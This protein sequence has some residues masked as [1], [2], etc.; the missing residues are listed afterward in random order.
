MLNV[1]CIPFRSDF[2]LTLCNISSSSWW[3]FYFCSNIYGQ[4][5][6]KVWTTFE[7]MSMRFCV[8]VCVC[9][10]INSYILQVDPSFKMKLHLYIL[11]FFLAGYKKKIL[12]AFCSMDYCPGFFEMLLFFYIFYYPHWCINYWLNVDMVC[13]YY[14]NIALRSIMSYLFLHQIHSFFLIVCQL[15]LALTLGTFHLFLWSNLISTVCQMQSF[16]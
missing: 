11:A 15:E 7:L 5:K 3:I 9:H 8:C 4:K 16:N 10:G 6:D 14:F 1:L 13:S 2:P 12:N